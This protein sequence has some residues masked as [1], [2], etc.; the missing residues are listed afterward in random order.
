[1]FTE[2]PSTPFLNKAAII[3]IWCHGASRE[4][5]DYDSSQEIVVEIIGSSGNTKKPQH[6]ILFYAFF[7]QKCIK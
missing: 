2:A 7:A 5:V 1:V 3:F 6:P 4:A